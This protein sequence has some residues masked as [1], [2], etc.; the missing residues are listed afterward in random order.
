MNL[1][2]SLVTGLAAIGL[3]VSIA[4]PT[5]AAPPTETDGS[6]NGTTSSVEVSGGGEFDAY[7]CGDNNLT[8]QSAPTASSAGS[9][10]GTL[11]ICYDDTLSY[12][13]GFDTTIQAT[14]PFTSVDALGDTPIPAALFKITMLHNV[15]QLHWSSDGHSLLDADD[16]NYH[17]EVA[18]PGYYDENGSVP[19]QNTP[20]FVAWSASNSLEQARTV[21]FSYNGTG[22]V[23]A[24]GE[25]DVAL[26]IPQG[27]SPGNYTTN[28]TLTI[29]AGGQ[30]H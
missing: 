22:S 24:G 1:R 13:D 26:T 9:A 10:T 20:G 21:Q 12:H 23:A 27:T 15:G 2:K 4:S 5:L 25:I 19:N 30:V 7:F 3:M 16:P 18:D 8:E 29:V 17:P 14:T 11:T 28:L 6:N